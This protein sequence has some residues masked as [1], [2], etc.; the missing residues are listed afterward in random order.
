VGDKNQNVIFAIFFFGIVTFVN[1]LG[2]VNRNPLFYYYKHCLIAVGVEN[3]TNFGCATSL[4]TLD[5]L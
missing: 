5:K 3:H 1:C 2:I 4:A